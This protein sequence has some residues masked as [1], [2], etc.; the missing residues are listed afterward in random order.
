MSPRVKLACKKCIYN[1]ILSYKEYL[2]SH[3]TRKVYVT[4]KTYKDLTYY[5]EHGYLWYPHICSLRRI[6]VTPIRS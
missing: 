6:Y 5:L 4:S 1:M 2:N 3:T